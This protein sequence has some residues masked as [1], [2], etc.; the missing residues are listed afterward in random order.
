MMEFKANKGH[1]LMGNHMMHSQDQKIL[2]DLRWH[3]TLSPEEK[4]LFARDDLMRAYAKIGYNLEKE[5]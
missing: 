4:R 1:I 5:S 3:E 2:E